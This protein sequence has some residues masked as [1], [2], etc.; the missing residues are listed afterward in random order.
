[1]TGSFGPNDTSRTLAFRRMNG[2]LFLS[3]IS[4]V[5]HLTGS[6]GCIATNNFGIGSISRKSYRCAF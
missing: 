1:M 5:R 6:V 4:M 2:Y 3:S